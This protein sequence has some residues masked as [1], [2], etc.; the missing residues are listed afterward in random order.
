MR[1]EV[2]V[3]LLAVWCPKKGLFPILST[4]SVSSALPVPRPAF[5]RNSIPASSFLLWEQILV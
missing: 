4:E 1:N 3:R 5:P 2:L